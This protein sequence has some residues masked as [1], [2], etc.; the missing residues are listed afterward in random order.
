MGITWCLCLWIDIYNAACFMA[1]DAGE[2]AAC[3]VPP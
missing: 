1:K 3:T 2:I